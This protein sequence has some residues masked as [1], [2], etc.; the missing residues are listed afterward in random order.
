MRLAH[1]AKP[2]VLARALLRYALCDMRSGNH[3]VDAKSIERTLRRC[4]GQSAYEIFQQP[5]YAQ[6]PIKG[7][8]LYVS[9]NGSRTSGQFFGSTFRRSSLGRGFPSQPNCSM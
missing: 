9:D 3:Y 5:A 8:P 2:R 6:G 1:S 4:S 7:S